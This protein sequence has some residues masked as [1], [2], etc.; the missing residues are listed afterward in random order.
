MTQPY[1]IALDLDGTLLTNE[2]LIS[3]RTKL[4]LNKMK[5]AGH[6]LVISTGRP[7]RASKQY[8]AE[9]D[10]TTPIVNFN[11]AHV[12][13][14]RS[15]EFRT[16]HTTIPKET[17]FS[18]LEMCRSYNINNVITE[19]MDQVYVEKWDDS[20]Y[21]VFDM[22][23]SEVIIGPIDQKLDENPTSVLISTPRSEILQ[24]IK[25]LDQEHAEMVD[26][27]SWGYPSD[28]IEIIRKGTNKAVGLK[29][30]ADYLSIPM[31]RVVAFGDEENDLEMIEA[32]GHGVAMG[33][34]THSIKAIANH[35]TH[36]NE[37]DG[38]AS[39]LEQH[40]LQGQ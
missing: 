24:L 1:L 31:D 38:I 30:V 28:I 18:I 34:A 20:F 22:P 32:A 12:H 19:V 27:R 9:L 37:D 40:F 2:K 17:A 16:S 8:Y 35:I 15:H 11:G 29:R 23:K 39:F 14:P 25:A 3:P 13:H 33:N 26:Q 5:E 10:L 7:Y 6:Q 36:T 4:A 21:E